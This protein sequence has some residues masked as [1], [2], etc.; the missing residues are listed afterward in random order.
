M[1]CKIVDFY[2][3]DICLILENYVK[4]LNLLSMAGDR[5]LLVGTSK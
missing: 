3:T 5:T 4:M 1:Y 2:S